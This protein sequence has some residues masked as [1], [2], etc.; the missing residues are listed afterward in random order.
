MTTLALVVVGLAGFCVGL[1]VGMALTGMVIA[2]TWI[3]E[4]S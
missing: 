1:L 4:E 2:D 3:E